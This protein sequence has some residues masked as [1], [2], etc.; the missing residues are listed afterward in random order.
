MLKE[1]FPIN[2]NLHYESK[3]KLA[4]PYAFKILNEMG[5]LQNLKLRQYAIMLN[6]HI[7]LFSVKSLVLEFNHFGSTTVGLIYDRNLL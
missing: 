3:C 7:M 5:A 2:I 1:Q 4:H 6:K